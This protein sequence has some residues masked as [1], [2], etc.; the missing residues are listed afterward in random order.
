MIKYTAY[1]LRRIKK[2]ML[3][4]QQELSLLVWFYKDDHG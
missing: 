1:D 4:T 3:L 2:E